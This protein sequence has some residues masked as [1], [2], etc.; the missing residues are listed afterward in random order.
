[1]GAIDRLQVPTMSDA[2]RVVKSEEEGFGDEA[3]EAH[4]TQFATT[5]NEG[6][7]IRPALDYTHCLLLGPLFLLRRRKKGIEC[8]LRTDGL[9]IT[10]FTHR[11]VKH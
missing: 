3:G 7:P 4:E 9:V 11:F 8:G 6:P 2:R 5:V 1:M 10:I